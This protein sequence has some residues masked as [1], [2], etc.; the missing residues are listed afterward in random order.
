MRCF[1][2]KMVFLFPPIYHSRKSPI[3]N[4]YYRLLKKPHAVAVFFRQDWTP[5]LQSNAGR[6]VLCN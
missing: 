2:L 5:L 1:W 6:N 4:Q 3:C